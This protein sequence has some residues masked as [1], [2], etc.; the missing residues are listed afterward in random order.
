MKGKLLVFLKNNLEVGIKSLIFWPVLGI[1]PKD[2]IM[3]LHGNVAYDRG[4]MEMT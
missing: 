3:G 2:I 1:Y 4:K